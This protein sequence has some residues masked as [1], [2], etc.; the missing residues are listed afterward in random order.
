MM[1]IHHYIISYSPFTLYSELLAAPLNCRKH[2][3]LN[4]DYAQIS[5]DYK[6]LTL[7]TT[8]QFNVP[9]QSRKGTFKEYG[10][11]DG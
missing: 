4:T 2:V 9:T 5:N 3:K 11:A 7:L 1:Y 10:G 6:R 8:I